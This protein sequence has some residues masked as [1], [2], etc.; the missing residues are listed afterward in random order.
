MPDVVWPA[1]GNVIVVT[2]QY[3]LGALGYL[4]LG[5]N[6]YNGQLTNLGLRDQLL[7]LDWISENILHFG[8]DPTRVTLAGAEV[9][10]IDY[11]H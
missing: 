4:Y 3:R 10:I 2:I 6:G 1:A 7:A 11:Y 9:I 8:G 5:D